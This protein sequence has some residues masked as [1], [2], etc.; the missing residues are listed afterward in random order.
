[1]RDGCMNQGSVQI[2][3][4]SIYWWAHR[5]ERQVAISRLPYTPHRQMAA[6]SDP[7]K[8]EVGLAQRQYRVGVGP[9]S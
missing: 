5:E 9:F 3:R 6:L 1:M 4:L 7:Q 2:F 8:S